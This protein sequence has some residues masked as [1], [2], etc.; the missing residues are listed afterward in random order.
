M[1]HYK[2]LKARGIE[3]LVIGGGALYRAKAMAEKLNAPFPVLSDPDRSIYERY[4]LHKRLG[5]VQQSGTV[6]V[7]K[8]GTVRY[9]KRFTNPQAWI[10][11]AEI[12]SLLDAAAT[13]EA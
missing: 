11:S 6:L 2:E 8:E 5:L 4:N 1:R 13:L 3:V 9:I 12:T 10:G 7:D